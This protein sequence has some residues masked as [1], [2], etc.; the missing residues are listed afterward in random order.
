M[1]YAIRFHPDAKAELKR[2]GDTYG[3]DLEEK[4][5]IWLQHLADAAAKGRSGSSIDFL[6]DLE[7]TIEWTE[8]GHH[9]W[10]QFRRASLMEKMKAVAVLLR[11]RRP[12]WQ[13][14][15]SNQSFTFLDQ[16]SCDVD[17]VY[18]VDRV[19]HRIAVMQFEGLPGQQQKW[20]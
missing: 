18:E 20:P 10:R 5:Y 1:S 19:N 4:I 8:H 13:L 12:P 14:Q 15:A 9:A 11:S 17:V 16:C 6:E 3:R 2:C 7:N